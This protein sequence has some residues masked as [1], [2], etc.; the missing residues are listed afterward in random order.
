MHLSH[1]IGMHCIYRLKYLIKT[2]QFKKLDK[3]EEKDH[4]F[5]PSVYLEF[6]E[7]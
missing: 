1:N 2:E 6:F 5:D 3:P 4:Y 7:K